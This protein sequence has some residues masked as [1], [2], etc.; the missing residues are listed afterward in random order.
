MIITKGHCR[1]YFGR[2]ELFGDHYASTFAKRVCGRGLSR[3]GA[4]EPRTIDGARHAGIP[5]CG[6]TAT[7]DR[8]EIGAVGATALGSGD[9]E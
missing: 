3:H 7:I 1:E 8:Q 6:P 2:A 4:L 5:G 9:G